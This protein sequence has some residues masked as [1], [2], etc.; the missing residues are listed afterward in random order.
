MLCTR[1]FAALHALLFSFSY[2]ARDVRARLCQQGL[3][4]GAGGWGRGLGPWAG[5]ESRA[6]RR[7]RRPCKPLPSSAVRALRLLPGLL[8]GG[9]CWRAAGPANLQ[10]LADIH[11]ECSKHG[12]V[13]RVVV[14]RPP[15]PDQAAQLIGTEGYG[16]AFVQFLDV[17]GARKVCGG[18]WG[19]A[20]ARLGG[21]SAPKSFACAAR[22]PG[23][24]QSA[25]THLL[26]LPK[27]EK[28]QVGPW[29]DCPHR[30]CAAGQGGKGCDGFV[31]PGLKPGGQLGRTAHV[32]ALRSC[33]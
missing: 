31:S 5:E 2:F 20:A 21:G 1:H 18:P 19:E 27:P 24:R 9:P 14:P 13:L 30:N 4:G 22:R 15:V 6:G 33:L 26:G 8:T 11:D 25:G 23:S 32:A 10:V 3:A 7:G 17:E 16:K 28:R 29:A 12:T